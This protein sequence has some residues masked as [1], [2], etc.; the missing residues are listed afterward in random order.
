[1]RMQRSAKMIEYRDYV[2]FTDAAWHSR[3]VRSVQRSFSAR[4]LLQAVRLCA[5]GLSWLKK[6]VVGPRQAKMFAQ[7]RAL[8]SAPEEA[9]PLQLGYHFRDEIV[10]ACGRIREHHV[11]T[12]A[13]FFDELLLQRT[14]FE[15]ASSRESPTMTNASGRMFRCSRAASRDHKAPCRG[16]STSLR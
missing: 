11:E 6:L 1:M 15:S 10:L 9:A 2:D 3:G 12:V 7:S 4:H 5:Y 16:G 14:L 8:V 13:A